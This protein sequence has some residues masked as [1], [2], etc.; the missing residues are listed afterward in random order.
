ERG[1]IVLASNLSAEGVGGRTNSELNINIGQLYDVV[2]PDS[3]ALFVKFT[4]KGK[5][6]G[7][8]RQ[9]Y[10]RT[11]ANKVGIVAKDKTAVTKKAS[12]FFPGTITKLDK[13]E[14]ILIIDEK[15]DYYKVRKSAMSA[16]EWSEGYVNKGKLNLQ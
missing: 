15:K 11:N 6:V 1:E 4:E 14:K 16:G 13:G 3:D 5:V 12:W 10:A 8:F 2:A 7:S 9:V